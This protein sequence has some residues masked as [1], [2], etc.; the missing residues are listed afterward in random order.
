MLTKAL[1]LVALVAV[2]AE[3]D[4][5]IYSHMGKMSDVNQQLHEYGRGGFTWQEDHAYPLM[6]DDQAYNDEYSAALLSLTMTSVITPLVFVLILYIWWLAKCCCCKKPE[7]EVQPANNIRFGAIVAFVLVFFILLGTIDG[8][9]AIKDGSDRFPSAI[10]AVVDAMDGLDVLAANFD[11]NG[12]TMLACKDATTNAANLDDTID[13]YAASMSAVNEVIVDT[14]LTTLGEDLDGSMDD[15][16]DLTKLAADA[17]VAGTI[18]SWLIVVIFSVWGLYKKNKCKY[19]AG[20]VVAFPVFII[21]IVVLAICLTISVSIADFCVG[22]PRAFLVDEVFAG[23]DP[24]ATQFAEYYFTCKGTS[25]FKSVY[26]DANAQLVSL[27]EDPN[28]AQIQCIIDTADA[29]IGNLGAL[30]AQLDCSLFD[31]FLTE[32]IDYG[33]CTDFVEGFFHIWVISISCTLLF[34][35]IFVGVTLKEAPIFADEAAGGEPKTG[36]QPVEMVGIEA[37]FDTGV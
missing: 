32:I 4:G 24:A 15:I 21:M 12:M 9:T 37:S 33:I 13:A 19:G 25:P 31:N 5:D 8:G 10:T 30:E 20:K 17:C 27:K 18:I 16:S 35:L 2:N 14:G 7:A 28:A 23:D 1:L 26:E 34:W 11:T 3:G 22:D 36:E 6:S 29:G